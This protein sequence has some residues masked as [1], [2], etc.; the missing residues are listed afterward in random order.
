M[1]WKFIENYEFLY[2]FLITDMGMSSRF[3]NKKNKIRKIKISIKYNVMKIKKFK[4][5]KN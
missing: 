3:F 4:K 1:L 5:I 2:G